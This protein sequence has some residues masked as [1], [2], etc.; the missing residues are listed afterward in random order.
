MVQEFVKILELSGGEAGLEY[1]DYERDQMRALDMLAAHYVLLVFF[2]LFSKKSF[3]FL[4]EIRKETKKNAKNGLHVLH[5][6]IQ[7]PIR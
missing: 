3:N 7:Q 6:F 1:P 2:F 5:F 4:R